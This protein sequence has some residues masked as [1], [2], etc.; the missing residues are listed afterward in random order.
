[1]HTKPSTLCDCITDIRKKDLPRALA[2]TQTALP[3]HQSESASNHENL[4]GP[5]HQ[6]TAGERWD[7]GTGS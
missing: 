5:I 1:M 6:D 3:R 4:K 2:P 7:L